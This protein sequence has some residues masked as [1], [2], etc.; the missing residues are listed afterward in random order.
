MP[1]PTR[2]YATALFK[3]AILINSLYFA[4]H[5]LH[6]SALA[7]KLDMPLIAMATRLLK[8]V[9]AQE[10]T[11]TQSSQFPDEATPTLDIQKLFAQ[12][13]PPEPKSKPLPSTKSLKNIDL[14]RESVKL[15]PSA[16][17]TTI[18]MKQQQTDPNR[19]VYID[20]NRRCSWSG[21]TIAKSL[22]LSLSSIYPKLAAPRRSRSRRLSS[23]RA[24]PSRRATSTAAVAAA[25]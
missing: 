6:S 7:G 8:F 18:L 25:R 20:I 16:E 14:S 10:N 11:K 22:S 3:A 13:Q 1:L 9:S 2:K 5:R 19:I 17:I 12:P 24:S 23:T 15:L 21:K 4:S